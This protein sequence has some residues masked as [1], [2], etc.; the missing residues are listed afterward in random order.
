MRGRDSRYEKILLGR[1]KKYGAIPIFLG[2]LNAGGYGLIIAVTTS[3]TR[4][5]EVSDG[6]DHA[7]ISSGLGNRRRPT[8]RIGFDAV[9]R[10]A[11][12]LL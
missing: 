7:T 8:E 6:N 3:N 5:I 2:R 10:G 12:G 1:P 4:H 11:D 9:G